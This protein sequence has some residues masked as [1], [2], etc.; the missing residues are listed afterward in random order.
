MEH[1]QNL[2]SALKSAVGE[3]ETLHKANNDLR[4]QVNLSH[5]HRDNLEQ[6]GRKEAFRAQKVPESEGNEEDPAK[7]VIERANYVLSQ[8]PDESQFAEFK[9]YKVKRSD[10]QRCHRVGDQR[11]AISKKKIRPIIAK[12]K[13]FRLRMAILINKKKLENKKEYKENGEFITEDL[14]PF[15]NKLLWYTKQI[16]N[17]DGKNKFYHIHSRD[18]KIKAKKTDGPEKQ[19]W[20]TITT[21]HD[22]HKHGH[23]VDIDLLNENFHQ[24]EILK[25]LPFD[26]SYIQNCL[27]QFDYDA[28]Y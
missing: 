2:E 26:I 6:Y 28:N 16:K 11:R 1:T 19:E 24:F 12:F 10:F 13:D 15:R 25:P 17:N 3:I 22:F 9:N 18:G 4:T 7:L 14:T 20:I 8:I 27:G 23:D 21:P 5:F